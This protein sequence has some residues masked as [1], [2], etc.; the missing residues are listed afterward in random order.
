MLQ[1]RQR[2]EC[3]LISWMFFKWCYG[4]FKN[5]EKN[6]RIDN[7]FTNAEISFDI[8]G[9]ADS[10]DMSFDSEVCIYDR[11]SAFTKEEGWDW[12]AMPSM[13]DKE[14]ESDN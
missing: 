8:E 7:K 4:Q 13:Q 1:I 6:V 2:L 11:D 14:D 9:L 10:V 12:N 3:I 5:F